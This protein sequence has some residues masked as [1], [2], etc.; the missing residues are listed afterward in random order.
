MIACGRGSGALYTAVSVAF[1]AAFLGVRLGMGLP[2][3]VWWWWD[4]YGFLADPSPDPRLNK[5]LLYYALGCN[6]I[7]NSLNLLWGYKIASGIVKL[8][9]GGSRGITKKT[10]ARAKASKD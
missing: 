3:S 2:H 1:A 5:W 6:V 9:T 7:L 8:A 10:P 4:M